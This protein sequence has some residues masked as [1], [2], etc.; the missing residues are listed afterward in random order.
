MSKNRNY[1]V[2]PLLIDVNEEGKPYAALYRDC[3]KKARAAEELNHR[4]L[5][6][7]VNSLRKKAG[8]TGNQNS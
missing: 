5:Q 4:I 2:E 6:A 1:P 7:K 8:E 3:G